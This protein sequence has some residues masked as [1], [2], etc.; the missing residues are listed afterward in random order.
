M[1]LEVDFGTLVQ[2]AGV[3][4][5]QA[6]QLRGATASLDQVEAAAVGPRAAGALAVYVDHW[7]DR[8]RE[9][10][11]TSQ[12]HGEALFTA[13]GEFVFS[14]GTISEDL[15]GLLVWQS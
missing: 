1:T 11:R 10:Q 9:L 3:W 14:D 13:A 4:K 7:S 5:E 15:S 8:V 12:S 6:D 2:A